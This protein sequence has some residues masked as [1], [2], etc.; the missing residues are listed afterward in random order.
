VTAVIEKLKPVQKVR[1]LAQPSGEKSTLTPVQQQKML[2]SK[3]Y[4]AAYAQAMAYYT[5]ANG[6]YGKLEIVLKKNPYK[7]ASLKDIPKIESA[8][9]KAVK[10]TVLADAKIERFSANGNARHY[11]DFHRVDD[12]VAFD[13]RAYLL[14]TFT[15]SELSDYDGHP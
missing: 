7:E 8:I 3:E 6:K 11:R 4:Q 1:S 13:Y 14:V 12:D 15:C 5:S 9:K 10:G 2:K